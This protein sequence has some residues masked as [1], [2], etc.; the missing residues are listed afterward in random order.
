MTDDVIIAESG[1]CGRITLNRP[2]VLHALTLDMCRR[3]NAALLEW[4]AD[5]SIGAIIIDHSG[6]RGFCAGGDVR[7]L[8]H[9]LLGDRIEAVQ[10]FRTEY[11]MNDLLFGLRTPAVCFMDGPPPTRCI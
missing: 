8:Y 3:I 1:G 4:E 10:F 11:A 2:K 7:A 5:P 6:G 9:D